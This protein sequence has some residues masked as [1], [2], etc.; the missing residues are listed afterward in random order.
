ME[1][2]ALP[3]LLMWSVKVMVMVGQRTAIR[4]QTVLFVI[5]TERDLLIKTL[6]FM[7]A[8]AFLK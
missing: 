8:A 4:K 6:G 1:A 2:I 5:H 7:R 3:D